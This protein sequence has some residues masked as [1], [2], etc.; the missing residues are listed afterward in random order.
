MSVYLNRNLTQMPV[1]HIDVLLTP[2]KKAT[3]LFATTWL[4]VYLFY[5]AV[6]NQTP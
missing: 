3:L 2:R 4:Y 5:R 6:N 1:I